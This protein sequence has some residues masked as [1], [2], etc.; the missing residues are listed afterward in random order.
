VRITSYRRNAS[1]ILSLEAGISTMTWL[2][3]FCDL[4]GL[5]FVTSALVFL[6]WQLSAS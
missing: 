5:A 2:G 6:C 1:G 3:K 4:W